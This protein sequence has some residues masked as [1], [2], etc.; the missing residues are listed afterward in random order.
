[1]VHSGARLLNKFWGHR[2]SC[3]FPVDPQVP[4][5]PPRQSRVR[6]HQ[7]HPVYFIFRAAGTL[8]I[9]LSLMAVV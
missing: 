8:C 5:R 2:A 1:M 7:V 4:H 9:R 3:E 6:G